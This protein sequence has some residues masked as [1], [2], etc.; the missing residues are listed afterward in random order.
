MGHLPCPLTCW[1]TRPSA[2]EKPKRLYAGKKKRPTLKTQV[3]THENGELRDRDPG[4]R[5]PSSDQRLYEHSRVET[6][7]PQADK[8]AD[9][10]YLGLPT[11]PPPP[12]NPKAGNGPSHRKHRTASL[13][14]NGC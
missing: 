6:T 8:Q 3:P 1:K 12:R 7:F 10:G 4:H 2:K 11:V 13:P 14:R 9:L 5:G